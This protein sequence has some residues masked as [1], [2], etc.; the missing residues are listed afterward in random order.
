[1]KTT[2]ETIIGALILATGLCGIFLFIALPIIF[3]HFIIKFW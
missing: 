2:F 3:L 1:M